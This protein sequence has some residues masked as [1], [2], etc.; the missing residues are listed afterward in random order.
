MRHVL[1]AALGLTLAASAA[2][3]DFEGTV[4]SRITMTGKQA[5]ERGHGTVRVQVSPRGARMA[6]EMTTPVGVVKMTVLHLKA[7]PGVTYVID[8]QKKTYAELTHHPDQDAQEKAG[9]VTVKKLGNERVAGYD[10]VHALV[11]DAE[12][13]K[14]EM[15]VTKAL[16]GAESFWAAQMGEQGEG[17]GKARE[18]AKS[19]RDAGLDGWPLKFKSWPGK[20]QEVVW[21]T[22]KVE[23][24]SL[25]SSLF[26]LSGY[27]KAEHGAAG[28]GVMELSPEQQKKMDEAMKRQREQM[29]KMS[30]EER[31]RLEE[32]MKSMQNGK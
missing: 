18:M 30:P 29:K 16:G 20:D 24:R 28:M 17:G 2:A 22:V 11:T 21:E 12:G 15:W 10:C 23:K 8:E 9:K 5:E 3:R 25:P 7:K 4:E 14:T 27:Q 1:V 26:S 19:L 32:T 6:T 13:E 31:K